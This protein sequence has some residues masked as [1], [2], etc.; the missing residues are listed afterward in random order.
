MEQQQIEK[1]L[2][3]QQFINNAIAKYNITD[4]AVNELKAKYG[5]LTIAGTADKDTYKVVAAGVSELRKIRTGIEAKRK[6]L[7]DI[8]LKYGKAVDD[9][10]KRL[11]ALV[12]PLELALK[13]EQDRI[14][15]QAEAEKLA[16]LRRRTQL[17]IDAGF[18]WDGN[19]YV[20]GAV[21]V[22]STNLEAM[23]LEALDETIEQGKA[24]VKRIADAAAEAQRKLDE[25]AAENE[26]IRLENEATAKRL[27]EQAAAMGV[28]TVGSATINGQPAEVVVNP[29][30]SATISQTMPN[31]LKNWAPVSTPTPAE[32]TAQESTATPSIGPV[33]SSLYHW[34]YINGFNAAIAMV[35]NILNSPEKL[36]RDAWKEK[37]SQLKP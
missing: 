31:P 15:K 2:T 11:T 19:F 27:Q 22:H 23:T 36:T 16:E 4:A 29:D 34:Q 25:Q 30:G 35:I 20:A 14:D 18:S 21:M 10:A 28:A 7:K 1:P 8:A 26:R 37:I 24:E 17:L 32:P 33:Y 13:T 12:Q 6:E 5:N 9:E 3:D